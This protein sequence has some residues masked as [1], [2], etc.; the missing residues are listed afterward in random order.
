MRG[1]AGGAGGG[2]GG[3]PPPGR[4]PAVAGRISTAAVR[5]DRLRD[6]WEGPGGEG[7]PGG[8]ARRRRPRRRR[9]RPLP[10]CYSPA[11]A[12]AA[13]R[14]P[15]PRERDLCRRALPPPG[16]PPRGG[17]PRGGS[18]RGGAP[19][20][21]PSRARHGGA[22]PPLPRRDRSPG[23][24]RRRPSWARAC[25]GGGADCP[26]CAPG[27]SRRRARGRSRPRRVARLRVPPS[28]RRLRAA[29]WG[30]SARCSRRARASERTGSAAMSATHP[31]RLETRT[32][33][34]N[35]CA[36]RGLARKPP[37]RNEGEGRRRW[38]RRRPPA[39]RP[40]V[41]PS[42]AEVGSRGPS[43]PPRAHHR[44]VSPAAP[45]RWSTSARVRTRKMVNYAWAGRSQRKLWWRSVAVLT[46]KSVVRPGY[47]GERLIEPSSS[48][49]PPK[50]PSG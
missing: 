1:W 22:G 17:P 48:W 39:V 37:W 29:G 43:S 12:A 16:V 40:P 19:V 25:G 13:R 28:P 23:P 2:V 4:R 27:V 49:F 21:P 35:T 32:K 20:S 14:I 7:G 31:T 15:G 42:S 24:R 33:E 9:A 38:R 10:G 6:G 26:Q 8:R 45:G 44:P 5:R 3:G 41:R 18:P 50:F 34:S 46:C 36:S 30:G 11:P 47:R